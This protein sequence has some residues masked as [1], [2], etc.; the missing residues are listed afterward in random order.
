MYILHMRPPKY[1]GVYSHH[2][3]RHTEKGKSLFF[4]WEKAEGGHII[5]QVDRAF[6][7]KGEPRHTSAEELAQNFQPQPE[8]LAVPMG[9]H[10]LNVM[11]PLPGQ[12]KN[13]FSPVETITEPGN[14][15]LQPGA[16][17]NER[18]PDKVE[19]A[20]REN[21][22]KALLRL[23][24]PRER[25]AAILA[26]EQLASV[27]ENITAAHKHMFRDFGV[28][29]RQSNMPDLA[30][31]FG[32]RVLEMAPNDDHAHFNLARI[33]CVLGSYNEAVKHIRAAM[34]IDTKEPI[35]SRMLDHIHKENKR[36][37]SRSRRLRQG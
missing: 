28:K 30:L 27:S 19:T 11:H 25:Q 12:G 26:L 22:R 6:Q 23:K 32:K 14:A 4:V 16:A 18:P 29:L 35:Y 20:L 24:R 2:Q 13:I 8:L 1:I 33:L 7:P 3:S 5:Q 15:P 9:R 21:F 31:L 37:Q 36:S 10:D 17:D 34:R